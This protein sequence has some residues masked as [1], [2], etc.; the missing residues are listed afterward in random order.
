VVQTRSQWYLDAAWQLPG[1]ATV[2]EVDSHKDEPRIALLGDHRNV[3]W[4]EL[5]QVSLSAADKAFIEARGITSRSAY[6]HSI[7]NAS[8]TTLTVTDE[9]GVTTTFTRWDGKEI[10]KLSGYPVG[11][12]MLRGTRYLVVNDKGTLSSVLH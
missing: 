1:L 3:R 8:H 5:G 7:D 12:Y 4:T 10:S 2:V 11:I 9:Q 6:A